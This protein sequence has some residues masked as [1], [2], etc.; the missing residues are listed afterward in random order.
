MNRVEFKVS[1]KKKSGCKEVKAEK[2][3]RD[4]KTIAAVFTL[5]TSKC[6]LWWIILVSVLGGILLIGILILI[7][8]VPSAIG[9]TQNPAILE[10]ADCEGD[11]ESL[12]YQNL[13]IKLV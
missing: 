13:P 10:K 5:D 4:S 2:A 6:N 1:T 8:L 7:L 12:N 11:D 3:K 9:P